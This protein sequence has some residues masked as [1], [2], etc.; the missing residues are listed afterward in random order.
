MY[1]VLSSLKTKRYCLYKVESRYMT[2]QNVYFWQLPQRIIEY[3]FLLLWSEKVNLIVIIIL[4]ENVIYWYF[5]QLLQQIMQR[6]FITLLYK[7]LKFHASY[8]SH[9]SWKIM[10]IMTFGSWQKMMWGIKTSHFVF[11]T[12]II[13]NLQNTTFNIF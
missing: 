1:P 6:S 5:W 2:K 3:N 8:F 12:A 7:I 10:R 13:Q 11:L 4:I 9:I